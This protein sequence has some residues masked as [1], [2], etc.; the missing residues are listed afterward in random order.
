MLRSRNLHGQLSCEKFK[1]Q[2]AFLRKGGE[3]LHKPNWDDLRYVLAVADHRSVNAAARAL[4]VNHATVLRRVASFEDR[5]GEAVFRRSA[6]GY[7]VRPEKGKVI[8]ALRQVE[9]AALAVDRAVQGASEPLSG[10]VRVT[11]TDTFCAHLLPEAV[12]AFRERVDTVR[13]DLISSNT[14]LDLSRLDADLT[15]R[16]TVRLP[17]QLTGRKA[18]QSTCAVYERPGAP[19]RWLGVSGG[20]A[21]VPGLDWIADTIP[22]DQ[23]GDSADSFVTLFHMVK[24]GLGRAVLPSILAETCAEL[25][26]VE[27][28]MPQI[29]IDLWVA[30]HRDFA[31]APRIRAV[32]DF[33]VAFL[34]QRLSA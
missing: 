9:A 31:E 27:T 5:F 11:S 29:A 6:Q 20:L 8:D 15:V 2:S 18:G 21:K 10:T 24:L 7:V 14:H 25:R 3:I 22:A 17:D 12:A 16:P 4:G 32:S 34:G 30:T 33:L 19:P 13:I 28:G 23:I 1:Y 26:R